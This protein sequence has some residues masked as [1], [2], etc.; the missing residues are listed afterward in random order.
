MKNG[1][2]NGYGKAPDQQGLLWFQEQF[3]ANYS[4]TLPC[5]NVVPTIFGSIQLE[6]DLGDRA[7]SMGVSFKSHTCSFNLVDSVTNQTFRADLDLD[8]PNAWKTICKHV[9][10]S[11]CELI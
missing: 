7:I 5:P 3:L 9:A 4:T 10:D 1:W 8:N 2:L 11:A 6:W